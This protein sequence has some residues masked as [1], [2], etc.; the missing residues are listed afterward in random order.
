MGIDI[1]CTSFVVSSKNN[2]R[3]CFVFEKNILQEHILDDIKYN[4]IITKMCFLS[5][6]K[7]LH[8]ITVHQYKI[9]MKNHEENK[10]LSQS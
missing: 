3:Y 4:S 2:I 7:F 6:R 8:T 5:H 10:F 1:F 9:L